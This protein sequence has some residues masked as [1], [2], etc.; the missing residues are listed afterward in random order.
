MI[1]FKA[2]LTEG[3]SEE[4]SIDQLITIL[5][6]NCK[7][8]LS[9][10][11]YPLIY[12]GIDGPAGLKLVKPSEFTRVSTSDAYGNVYTLLMDSLDS[13]KEYPKRSKSII[14]TNNYATAV[15]YGKAHLV[16]PFDNAIWGVTAGPD[17]FYSFDGMKRDLSV[18]AEDLGKEIFNIHKL[19]KK[20]NSTK[21][22]NGKDVQYARDYRILLSFL[23][24]LDNF[25]LKY[26]DLKETAPRIL[27]QH[28]K[29]LLIN[30]RD[31]IRKSDDFLI[32][33]IKLR[34]Y[35]EISVDK[36]L[37]D[38]LS[39]KNNDFKLLSTSQLSTQNTSREMWTDSNAILIYVMYQS[40]ENA[41]KE[42]YKTLNIKKSIN[43][44][45]KNEDDNIE[46]F[47]KLLSGAIL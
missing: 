6:K 28:D 27:S 16:I 2:F 24:D 22:S 42:I 5:R 47:L 41:L 43:I 13:W 38:V 40:Y 31:D 21:I 14:G 19:L 32:K 9:L 3:R 35:K 17:I 7:K 10:N 46:I 36:I 45:G 39:P 33:L 12:R 30:L 8:F 25:I 18:D 23:K 37:N 44:D 4:L 15:N 29:E 20:Y 11:K 34:I 26:I 1:S